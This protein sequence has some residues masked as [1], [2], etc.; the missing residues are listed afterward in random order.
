MKYFLFSL[1]TLLNVS[2]LIGQTYVIDEDFQSGIP[3]TWSIITDD[4][5][6]VHTDV[7]EFTSAWI[8]KENPD[9]VG[10]SVIAATSYFQNGG[11][12]SRWIITPQV[13]LGTYG[14]FIEWDAKS[15][16]PSFPD[17]YQVLIS[18]TN[19]SLHNF[20]DTIFFT[21]FE[22]PNW[23][24]RELQLADST[25]SGLQVY[26]A[27]VNDSEDQFILYLDNIKVRVDDP[28]STLD[29]KNESTSAIY[30]NP[31][32]HSITIQTE[33][34]IERLRLL[35]LRGNLLK[36]INEEV[37]QI[38]DLELLPE[39]MYILNVN[40]KNGLSEN[41]KLIKR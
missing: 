15:H 9:T 1:F 13:Q 39:G 5:S 22:L 2:L 23:T 29:L 40:Y 12:A 17:G 38:N 8:I 7:D 37:Y 6:T 25:Y 35:D 31:F 4:T 3:G 14:N 10:D 33:M 41:R 34:E 24:S 27:F 26:F 11:I 21:D 18:T 36:E 16:D 28:L 20:T 32:E 30:P 19:D